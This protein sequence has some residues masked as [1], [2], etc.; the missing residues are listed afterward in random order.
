M[1]Q[2]HE[3]EVEERRHIVVDIE[4]IICQVGLVIAPEGKNLYK[5]IT[6]YSMLL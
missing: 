5:V 3:N 1:V 4:S 2:L 6:P